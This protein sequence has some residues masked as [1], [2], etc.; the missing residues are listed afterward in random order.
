MVTRRSRRARRTGQAVAVAR[1][2]N[3]LA[4]VRAAVLLLLFLLL[5]VCLLG[6]G[7]PKKVLGRVAG[8]VTFEGQPVTDGLIVFANREKGVFILAELGPDGSYKA[9]TADGFGLPP[10]TYQVSITPP[11]SDAPVGE[12]PK[13]PEPG[14]YDNIPEKYRR[15]ETSGLTLEVKETKEAED[16]NS[17]NVDM[18]P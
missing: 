12:M 5:G 17:L 6:C 8:T 10:G 15:P 4:E 2:S 3:V 7:G 18:E 14:A 16:V 11:V 1:Q 13:M 9:E